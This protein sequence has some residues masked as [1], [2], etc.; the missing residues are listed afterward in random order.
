MNSLVYVLD[1]ILGLLMGYQARHAP[2]G[3]GILRLGEE[4]PESF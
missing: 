1:I 4:G 3:V 2:L